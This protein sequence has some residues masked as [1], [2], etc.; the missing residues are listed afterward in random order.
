MFSKQIKIY[1][2]FSVK[3]KNTK[4]QIAE[5]VEP[6]IIASL[7]ILALS[8]CLKDKAVKNKDIV[9]PIP[10]NNATPTMC[11]NKISFGS[12]QIF[13]FFLIK[14]KDEMQTV[15]QINNAKIIPKP[16]SEKICGMLSADNAIVV[17]ANAKIGNIK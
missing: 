6:I 14:S 8:G 9:K 16:K 10:A 12:S 1:S 4:P 5:S 7:A 13:V 17:L 11:L 2:F 3:D 15:F